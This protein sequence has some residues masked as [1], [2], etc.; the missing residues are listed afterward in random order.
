MHLAR[1]NLRDDFDRMAAVVDWLDCC[2]SG[3]LDALLD[4]YAG[5]ASLEC[6]CE[7]A[8]ITGRS[9]LAAYWK[10]RLSSPMPDAFG[11]EEI[12]PG[13]DGVTLVFLSFDGK[14]V[15]MTFAFDSHGKITRTRCGPAPAQSRQLSA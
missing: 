14:L 3:N 6:A 2:R 10:P 12:A 8:R 1:S 13:D 4:L 9:G 7:N 5:N 11:L 15:R